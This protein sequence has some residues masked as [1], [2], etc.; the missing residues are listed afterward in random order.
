MDDKNDGMGFVQAW[1]NSISSAGYHLQY[2]PD[3][4][5][6][7]AELAMNFIPLFDICTR[8]TDFKFRYDLSRK[9]E[10][11]KRFT[12]GIFDRPTSQQ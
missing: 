10:K 5:N 3:A 4:T 9:S 6:C 7:A 12:V 8:Q 2:L 1:P 11:Y